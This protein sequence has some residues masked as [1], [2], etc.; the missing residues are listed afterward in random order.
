MAI[1]YRIGIMPGPWPT[2]AGERTFLFTLAEFCE[3]SDIDSH[4]AL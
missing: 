4:L 2:G 3:K 1:K